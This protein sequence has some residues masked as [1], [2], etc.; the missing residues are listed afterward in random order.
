ML[1]NGSV[2]ENIAYGVADATM[3]KIVMAARMANA[4]SFIMAMPDAYDTQIGERGSCSSRGT[5]TA[6]P[7]A[8]KS[9]TTPSAAAQ[10]GTPE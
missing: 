3:D 9:V 10:F 4:D 2:A 7:A 8:G 1:F 6:A 5:S